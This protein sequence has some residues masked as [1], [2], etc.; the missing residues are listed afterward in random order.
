M[1]NITTGEE[2]YNWK[3]GKYINQYGHVMIRSDTKLHDKH[4]GYIQEHK[5]VMQKH[6]GRE[7]TKDE[8]IIHINGNVQDN[9]L[10]NLKLVTRSEE[11][12]I[13]NKKDMSKRF[14][15]LCGSY[16]TYQRKDNGRFTW[17]Y[18]NVEGKIGGI[19]DEEKIIGYVCVNCYAKSK[20]KS[21][22]K[23]KNH[24]HKQAN[25]HNVL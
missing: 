23:Y 11:I 15:Y 22:N 10:E 13:I 18:I 8:C 1:T 21:K 4:Q 6:L 16:S 20:R 2:H 12:S 14:C 17:Y 9:R 3:G 7:L 25:L 24:W 19:R 5:D